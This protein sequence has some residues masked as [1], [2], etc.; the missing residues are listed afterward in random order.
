[1]VTSQSLDSIHPEEW[2]NIAL[3]LVQFTKSAIAEIKSLNI[4]KKSIMETIVRLQTRV[5]LAVDK[6][7]ADHKSSEEGL[8]KQVRELRDQMGYRLT[9]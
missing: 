5:Q 6:Q 7:E 1:M 3:P 9:E 2:N 4:F 8:N